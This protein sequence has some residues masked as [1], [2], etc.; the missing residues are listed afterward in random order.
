MKTPFNTQ[1]KIII[2]AQ[3]NWSVDIHT[4]IALNKHP[5]KMFNPCLQC[6]FVVLEPCGRKPF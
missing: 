4:V 6:V 2:M 1:S 3:T 5:L